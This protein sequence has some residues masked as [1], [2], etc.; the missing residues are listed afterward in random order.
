M[1][2]WPSSNKNYGIIWAWW[3]KMKKKIL[4]GSIQRTKIFFDFAGSEQTLISLLTGLD[5][6]AIK[7]YRL[8]H[9]MPLW[10][11]ITSVYSFHLTSTFF[12]GKSRS[13]A[14]S[15]AERRG[16]DEDEYFKGERERAPWET[17]VQIMFPDPLIRGSARPDLASPRATQNRLNFSHLH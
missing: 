9:V 4:K 12:H 16:D 13:Y 10:K 5:C 14:P 17:H 6:P 7:T 15:I 11:R 3:V 2:F 8:F 1:S